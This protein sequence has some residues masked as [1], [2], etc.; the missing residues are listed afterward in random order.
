MI[1]KL[2]TYETISEALNKAKEENVPKLYAKNNKIGISKKTKDLIKD[3]ED[4]IMYTNN[5]EANELIKTN[6]EK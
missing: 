2:N 3:R 5:S 1:C 4:A 6:T